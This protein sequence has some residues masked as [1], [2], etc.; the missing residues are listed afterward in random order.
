MIVK[1][2]GG[3]VGYGSVAGTLLLQVLRGEQSHTDRRHNIRI[4]AG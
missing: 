2:Y 4:L 3:Y 1:I